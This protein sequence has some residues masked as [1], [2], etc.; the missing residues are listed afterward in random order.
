MTANY[1]SP[2]D[3][4]WTFFKTFNAKDAEKWAGVMS[5]PHL[6]VSARGTAR[7]FETPEA[8]SSGASWE[9][10][11]AIGWVRTGGIEPTRLHESADKVHL[12]GGRT[13]YNA[14]DQPILSNR[15]SYILTRL[16]GHT[17]PLRSRLIYGG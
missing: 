8:Y 16:V 2:E 12:A 11:E 14:S 10:I 3:A 7:Y 6:R 9:R 17:G 15:V 1:A 5:Y 4:Y 13:R